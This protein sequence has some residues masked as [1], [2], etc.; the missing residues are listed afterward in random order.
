MK[1]LIVGMTGASGAVMGME[2]LRALKGMPD[3]ESHLVATEGAE[4]TFGYE[5]ELSMDE[6][7]GMADVVYDNGDIGAAI[8]SGSFET[9]GMI[10]IPCSMKTVAGIASG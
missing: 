1:R 4:V 9:E 3:V 10:V 2:L 8:S 6:V 5:T 7:R